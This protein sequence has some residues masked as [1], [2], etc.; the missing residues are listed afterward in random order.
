M[1]LFHLYGYHDLKAYSHFGIEDVFTE[2]C[3]NFIYEE[4][5]KDFLVNGAEDQTEFF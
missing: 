3:F 1:I 4:V 2:E 5:K